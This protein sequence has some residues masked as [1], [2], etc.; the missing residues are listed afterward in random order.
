MIDTENY[1]AQ[2]ETE[3]QTVIAE[4]QTVGRVNPDNPM[5]W[6]A[7][8][9]THPETQADDN[10]VADNIDDYENNTAILKQLEIRFNEI[11]NALERIEKG[12]YGVCSVG[13]EEISEDRLNAN[14]AA[15]TCT[16]HME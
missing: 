7:L 2:L 1:K 10:V 16:A 14:P 12:T 8:E 5:D 11:K 3:L 9:P 4:L 6:E 15:D 13:G